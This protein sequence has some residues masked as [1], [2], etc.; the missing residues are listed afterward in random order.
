MKNEIEKLHNFKNHHFVKQ[1]FI[2]F[3]N[4]IKSSIKE[5]GNV[6]YIK[7]EET[8]TPGIL[9]KTIKAIEYCVGKY[10]F[11]YLVRSNIS[12][13][14]DFNKIPFYK[15]PQDK[16]GY[17]STK[18]LKLNWLDQKSGIHDK[19]YFKTK[20][21][22][23]T[24]IILN[25]LGV[26]YLL[27]NKKN[28]DMTIIDDVSIGIIMKKITTPIVICNESILTD[29]ISKSKTC[30]TFAVNK[31]HK[32]GSVFRNKSKSRK[33]DVTRMKKIVNMVIKN[34]NE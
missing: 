30:S 1:F 13:V 10:N 8:F 6:L 11:N 5:D 22:S 12:S 26:K 27:D 21:A 29:A 18:I 33:W 2:C 34:K 24:N 4:D 23:G 14:I 3:K 28:I 20:F 32:N 25:K 16:I 15:I 31:I 17:G 7:G 9:D 19:S